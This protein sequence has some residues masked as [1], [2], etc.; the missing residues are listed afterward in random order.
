[1]MY[2]RKDILSSYMCW[3]LWMFPRGILS[4]GTF[5]FL[6]IWLPSWTISRISVSRLIPLQQNV[7]ASSKSVFSTR[8]D[9]RST[10]ALIQNTQLIPKS[11]SNFLQRGPRHLCLQQSLQGIRVFCSLSHLK[12][13][14]P[15]HYTHITAKQV[16]GSPTE[17]FITHI[18]HGI[19][20]CGH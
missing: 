15:T 11:L 20:Q 10:G 18:S 19:A 1:M 6:S 9:I 5:F 13:P 17:V 7:V 8:G 4:L 12:P 3:L 14:A 2:G 16:A